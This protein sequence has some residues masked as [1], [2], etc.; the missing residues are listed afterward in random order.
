M[1]LQP[2]DKHNRTLLATELPAKIND[3]LDNDM[4]ELEITIGYTTTENDGGGGRKAVVLDN[5]VIPAILDA[6]KLTREQA[7]PEQITF[8]QEK[9]ADGSDD[10]VEVDD[11]AI[12]SK[13]DTGTWVSAWVWLAD[14]LCEFCDSKLGSEGDS[15]T[16][17]KSCL[18]DE[19]AEAAELSQD[20]HTQL[21]WLNYD[22]LKEILTGI[23]IAVHHGESEDDL[24]EAVRSNI[25]DGTLGKDVLYAGKP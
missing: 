15:D 18:A 25:E 11:D 16:M 20:D 9:Y 7:T 3:D 24:R 21:N 19:A 5:L 4:P 14:P 10:N 22:R 13:T 6:C 17:C 23:S 8:A 1:K 2:T 12:T